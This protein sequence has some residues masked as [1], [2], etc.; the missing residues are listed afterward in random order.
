[1]EKQQGVRT[2]KM[3]PGMK[4]P[5][6]P[7]NPRL[8]VGGGG[9]WRAIPAF[10]DAFCVHSDQVIEPK[11]IGKSPTTHHVSHVQDGADGTGRD[12]PQPLAAGSGM[13]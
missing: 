2:E 11:A 13:G 8:E 4:N 7:T 6:G 1:M 9:G 12:A 3:S 10:N 5:R